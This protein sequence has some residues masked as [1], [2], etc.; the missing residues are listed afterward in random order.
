MQPFAKESK[1]TS[2]EAE[3]FKDMMNVG[4]EEGNDSE[5]EAK[6]EIEGPKY[7]AVSPFRELYPNSEIVQAMKEFGPN[8][9]PLSVVGMMLNYAGN[10]LLSHIFT[11]YKKKVFFPLHKVLS[12]KLLE[13]GEILTQVKRTDCVIKKSSSM[14]HT[15]FQ[16]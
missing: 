15:F 7:E 5:E 10:H 1:G 4:L 13:N 12:V 14:H 6:T 2:K 16:D 3:K 11:Q 9:V 8:I